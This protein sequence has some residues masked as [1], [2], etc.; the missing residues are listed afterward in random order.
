VRRIRTSSIG[1]DQILGFF[2]LESA[3][4]RKIP[5]ATWTWDCGRWG[6]LGQLGDGLGQL[7]HCFG[8]RVP[9]L[10]IHPRDL[11]RGFWPQILLLTRELIERGYAP[12]TVS[13]LVAA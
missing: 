7:S 3:S 2:S 12:S 11:A 5:L 13:E 8:R 1:L 4:G 6:W 10:A 9:V